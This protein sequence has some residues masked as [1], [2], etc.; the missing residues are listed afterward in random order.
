MADGRKEMFYQ[1]G[2]EVEPGAGGNNG[3]RDS[4]KPE[5]GKKEYYYSYRFIGTVIK[6][7]TDAIVFIQ[8]RWNTN[9]SFEVRI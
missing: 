4:A 2:K 7:V 8:G 5:Q 3:K 1:R 9:I 6:I